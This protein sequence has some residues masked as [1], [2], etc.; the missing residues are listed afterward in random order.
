MS[1]KGGDAN[2][3]L[4]Q[5]GKIVIISSPSG[6][7]KTTICNKLLELHKND[8]WTFSIS[9]TTRPKRPNEADGREYYFKSES[10]FKA[11]EDSG[12]F[13]ESCLVHG[14]TYGTPSKPLETI[15]RDGG[16]ILLDIDYKGAKKIRAEYPEAISIFVSPPSLEELERRL[17]QRGTE[18]EESLRIRFRGSVEEMKRHVEFGHLVFNENL[19]K[20]IAE[21]DEVIK[22]PDTQKSDSNRERILEII[23]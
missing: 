20:A 13:A 21:V 18:S 2:S 12:E 4:G 10:E 1:S 19:E 14:N 15:L 7:G 22:N 11:M 3:A 23:G 8:A 5:P 16:V 9:A 6:G 17:R